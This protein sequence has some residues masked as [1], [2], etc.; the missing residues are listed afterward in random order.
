MKTFEVHIQGVAPLRMNR[1]TSGTKENLYTGASAKKMDEKEKIVDAY[2][3][4]YKNTDGKY[5]VEGRAIKA[6]LVKGAAKVKLGRYAASSTLKA[7]LYVDG[8]EIPLLHK[9]EPNI[10]DIPCKVPPKTGALVVKLFACF[11]E[12]E[13]KFNLII[14]DERIPSNTVKQSIIEAGLYAGLLDGR[15]DFGRFV[16]K[17]FTE[18]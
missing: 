2:N 16:L 14:T 8:R 1:L 18:V 15:P 11:E 4:T 10:I 3:R 9:R 7:T 17:E 5:I 6:C 12:W 13:L